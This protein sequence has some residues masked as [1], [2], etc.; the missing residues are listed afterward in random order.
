MPIDVT[1]LGHSTVVLDIDGV[2]LVAD[3]L[4]RRHAGVLRRRGRRPARTAWTGVDA[5][6]L[7]HLHHD[8]AEVRSLRL[9]DGAPVL[10][11]PENA[12]WVRR[13]GLER[14]GA[15]AG[16]VDV[17]GV[18]RSFRCECVWCRRCTGAADAASAERGQRP[19]RAGPVRHGLGRR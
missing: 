15:G 11:A 12:E 6:L 13:K 18:A 17:R 19:P 9:L 14:A 8:H 4:L 3:P 1:W 16:R 7:S 5:V 10:T 2:R